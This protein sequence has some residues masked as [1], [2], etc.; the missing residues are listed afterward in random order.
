M[1]SYA[2][3]EQEGKNRHGDIRQENV[4]WYHSIADNMRC[5][6]LDAVIEG[7]FNSDMEM[8]RQSCSCVMVSW[9]WSLLLLVAQDRGRVS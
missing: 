6:I 7:T 5:C 4:R 1:A 9:R 2:Y 8:S 3:E